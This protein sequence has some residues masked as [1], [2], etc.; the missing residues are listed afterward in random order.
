MLQLKVSEPL[1][2]ASK[3]RK[4]RVDLSRNVSYSNEEIQE[5]TF[6]INDSFCISLLNAVYSNGDRK[7]SE[8]N[9]WIFQWCIEQLRGLLMV[10]HVFQ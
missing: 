9:V 3:I 2:T 5:V 4:T 10:S 6:K 1:K 8:E 7:E